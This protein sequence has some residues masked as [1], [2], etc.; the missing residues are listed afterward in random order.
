VPA[1]AHALGERFD[2][3][4]DDELNAVLVA[5]ESDDASLPALEPAVLAPEY[6]G[7]GQ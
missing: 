5:L 4:S 1:S 7:G 6:R 3:L 2:D